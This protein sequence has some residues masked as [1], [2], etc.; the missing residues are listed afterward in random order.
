MKNIHLL[1]VLL[2]YVCQCAVAEDNTQKYLRDSLPEVW[3]MEQ[4]NFQ[5]TPSVDRWWE[6]F[7]DPQLK[8]LI[9][10]AVENNFNVL[11]AMKRIESARLTKRQTR[12]GYYPNLSTSLSW[13]RDQTAGTV[14]SEH[15]HPSSM[16]YWSLGLSMNWEID[17]FGRIASQI[18]ADNASY[19]ASVADYDAVL[20]SLCANLAKVYVDYRSMQA[21]ISIVE[22]NI[23]N[24][25]YQL[26]LAQARYDAGL[27]PM[28]DLVQARISVAQTRAAM[29]ALKNE[30]N[31][32][33]NQI[34]LLCG[35]YP[36]KISEILAEGNMPEMPAMGDVGVPMNLLRRRPDLVAAEKQLAYQAALVGVAKKDFLPTLSLSASVGTEALAFHRMFGKN[37]LSYNVMPQLSWTIFDGL[38]R[39]TK[40][41][42]ARLALQSQIDSYNLTVM[43]AVNEVNNAFSELQCADE[44]LVY[45]QI[46]V[47]EAKRQ[48]ELQIDRYV[49]G[50]NAF[51]DVAAAQLTLLG[52]Q[53]TLVQAQAN[54][55]TAY[56]GLYS[57]L[58]GGF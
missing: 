34:A 39:E 27:R 43:T 47:K 57:A 41:A 17:V 54:Q 1:L 38:T 6:S 58:G 29:P 14:H 21:Q 53:N 37:S 42:Q 48:L 28:L 4:Q 33:L 35:L 16:N 3:T 26:K 51:S 30:L 23:E 36:D 22:Q 25:Q 12:A 45:Q 13:Q 55:L 19:D 31:V 5:T 40:L 9:N 52:Y 2:V 15:A 10:I 8:K 11:T 32:D 46:L 20:V 18:K 50:L 49:Q 56:V 44:N 7:N 24:V